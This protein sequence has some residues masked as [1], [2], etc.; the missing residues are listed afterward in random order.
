MAKFLFN[1]LDEE[2]QET[3]FIRYRECEY[4]EIFYE[5][6]KLQRLSKRMFRIFLEISIDYRGD[7]R[8]DMYQS[9]GLKD[10][11]HLNIVA[12]HT[13]DDEKLKDDAFIN[14]YK[15]KIKE[16]VKKFHDAEYEKKKE[17][18]MELIY[19]IIG[20]TSSIAVK[21]NPLT[22]IDPTFSLEIGIDPG[23]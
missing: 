13:F 16:Y 3:L 22:V 11:T 18:K 23:R 7:I 6:T 15:D 5:L 20:D 14:E 21:Q 10:D 9:N 2:S 12:M 8:L 1:D 17:R 19:A 4:G